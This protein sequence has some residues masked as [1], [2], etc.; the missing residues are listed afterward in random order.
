MYEGKIAKT[1]LEKDMPPK[2]VKADDTYF[3]GIKDRGI[4]EFP[5]SKK[6]LIKLFPDKKLPI[7]AFVKEKNISFNEDGDR[8][9]IVEFLATM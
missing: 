9:K 3:L 4:V 8:I 5:G 7:E 1:S 2:F 6:Q